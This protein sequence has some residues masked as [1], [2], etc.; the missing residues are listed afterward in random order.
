MRKGRE[1]GKGRG[2]RSK[3]AEE[4]KWRGGEMRK[5]RRKERKAR[6]ER[7]LQGGGRIRMKKRFVPGSRYYLEQ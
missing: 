5:G 6:E 1:E 2:T 7:S 4:W 3:R